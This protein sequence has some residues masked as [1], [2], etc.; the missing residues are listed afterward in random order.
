MVTELIL[1]NLEILVV[2]IYKYLEVYIIVLLTFIRIVS[3][4]STNLS[5]VFDVLIPPTSSLLEEN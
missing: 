1:R 2:S 5:T 3:S 4:V